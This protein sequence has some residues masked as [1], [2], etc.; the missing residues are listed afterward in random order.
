VDEGAGDNRGALSAAWIP[1]A[2]ELA[3]ELESDA[4][5]AE[6]DEATPV[7][8]DVAAE[9]DPLEPAHPLTSAIKQTGPI[10]QLKRFRFAGTGQP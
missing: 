4:V 7:P 1:G 8:D 3:A 9:C 10:A 6:V 2:A 5:D